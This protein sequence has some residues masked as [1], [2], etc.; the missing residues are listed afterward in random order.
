MALGR[1]P[2]P[3]SLSKAVSEVVTQ[4][5]DAEGLTKRKLTLDAGLKPDTG[6]RLQDG[7]RAWTITE[8][9]AICSVLKLKVSDVVAEAEKLVVRLT[10]DDVGLAADAGYDDTPPEDAQGH[11]G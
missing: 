7:L 1:N 8:L 9:E 10:Q 5:R 2:L 11:E 4:K 6:Y 3:T